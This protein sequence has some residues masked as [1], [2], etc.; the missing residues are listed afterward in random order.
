MLEEV[1]EWLVIGFML[2]LPVLTVSGLLA[3]LY[4]KV[5]PRRDT[6]LRAA[7]KLRMKRSR[8]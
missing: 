2:L 5:N 8:G 1:S 4:G 6:K 7:P 3:I